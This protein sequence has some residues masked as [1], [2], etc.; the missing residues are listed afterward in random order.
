MIRINLLPHREE[1]RKARQRQMAFI[2]GGVLIMGALGVLM[3]YVI[4]SGL[5]EHQNTRNRI[6]KDEITKL[7]KQIEEIKVLKEKTKSLLD[8][9]KV[10]EELQSNRAET[11]HL[12][13]QLVRQLPEGIYLKSI[14]QTGKVVNLQG[15][16]Q[17][18]ARVSTL[19]RNLE[20]SPWLEAPDLVEI[21]A[22]TVN[23]LRANEFTLN[24]KIS[25]PE[26]EKKAAPQ[27]SAK[28]KKS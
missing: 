19:M 6:F 4:I 27:A 22:A 21:K 17:S 7:D 24:V 5:I 15:Y 16:A 18:Q 26:A 20:A 28:D 13:D 12:I 10:V 11:V 2:A 3:G 25:R 8:R 1:A 23:N 9:K 14:K